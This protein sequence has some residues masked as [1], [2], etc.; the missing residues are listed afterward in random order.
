MNPA[1]INHSPLIS[2]YEIL[3]R[4]DKQLRHSGQTG[5]PISCDDVKH[6]DEKPLCGICSKTIEQYKAHLFKA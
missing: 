1:S 4:G 5:E 2:G 3:H 6:A